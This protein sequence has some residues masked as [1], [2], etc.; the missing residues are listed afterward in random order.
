MERSRSFIATPPGA[1]IKEQIIDRG[2][3]QKEFAARMGMSEK[4]ISKLINGEV[5][6]TIDVARRLEMVLGL[7]AQFWCNLESIYREKIAKV[8]EENS[9]DADIAIAKKMPY[10]EMAKNGWVNDT[11]K[12]PERVI[13]LRKFFEVAQLS[14]LQKS[15]V[16][17]I[18]CR[19][20]SE[21]EKSDYALIAWAQR[22]KVEARTKLTN[23]INIALL[24]EKI[25]QIRRMTV[26]PPEE[27]CPKLIELLANCGIAIIFLPHIGGSFLHGATFLDGNKIVVGLTVRGKDADKFWFSLFHELA[28]IIY[29]HISSKNGT[30]DE[31]EAYAD[32]YAK[33]TLISELQYRKFVAKGD[34]SKLSLTIF[35]K[36][37][38]IDVGI[39]VGRLQKEGYIQY[40]WHNDLKTRYVLT[41]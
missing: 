38:G 31:D 18:A 27:F 14:F 29:G 39:V 8:I 23:P 28:H 6:L 4:H 17:G 32:E 33:N 13:N 19:K 5:Q 16:P 20:L 22:A 24:T 34:F 2:I 11:A 26:M 21:T 41:L 7:P 1:T 35:A 9:M 10:K 36:Q 12:W 15:L 3:N 40:N 30:T 25:P 37:I